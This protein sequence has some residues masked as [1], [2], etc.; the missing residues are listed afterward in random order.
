MA[1]RVSLCCSIKSANLSSRTPRSV[2]GSS[3]QEGSL[4]ALRAALT[5]ISISSSPA[6]YTDVI[7]VSLLKVQSVP[8][9]RQL[10]GSHKTVQRYIR[11]V[12]GGKLLARLGG[13]E[14][15]VD[16]ETDGLGVA[17]PIGGSQLHGDGG[18]HE[19]GTVKWATQANGASKS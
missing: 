5:A 10:G 2:A 1:A 8:T 17:A 7:S 16:E 14:L 4:R 12:H 9:P 3:F 13:H 15:I 6:A 18:H 11:R 19:R